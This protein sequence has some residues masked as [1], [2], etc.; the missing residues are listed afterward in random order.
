MSSI[1]KVDQI[2]LADGST[3]TAGD[4]GVT[5]GSADL[6]T[7]SVL[8][9]IMIN[10]ATSTTDVTSKTWVEI[11]SDLRATITPINASN[12]LLLTCTFQFSGRNTNNIQAFKF[13]NITDSAE[14]NLH[15]G[16]GSRTPAHGGIRQKD[17]DVNDTDVVTITTTVSA[18]STSARTYGVYSQ[19]E[20]SAASAVTKTFFGNPSNDAALLIVRPLFTIQE[21]AG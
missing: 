20:R 11:S 14:V 4:L 5:L 17:Y 9:T 15:T 19:S 21:I 10:P 1:I 8:Q 18:G 3:P 16:D 12:T 7:G 13:Y 6:P 2:Q